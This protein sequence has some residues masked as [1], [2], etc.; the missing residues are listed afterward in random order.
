MGAS[1]ELAFA[2]NLGARRFGT[3][4]HRG[5]ELLAEIQELPE[6]CPE[7]IIRAMR[8]GLTQLSADASVASDELELLKEDLNRVLSVPKA[9]WVLQRHKD[10]HSEFELW[11]AD[12]QR[13]IIIDR[14]FIDASSGVRWVIDYKTS[15]PT[16]HQDNETFL[17]DQAERYRAQLQQYGNAIRNWDIQLGQ[18]R[19]VKAAL[20]FSRTAQLHEVEI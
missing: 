17:Q 16:A 10:A 11:L 9:R 7:A 15:S 20:L 2:N 19:E 1:N 4:L 6:H 12:E 5:L 13:Q 14:T 8:F 18:P 3:V